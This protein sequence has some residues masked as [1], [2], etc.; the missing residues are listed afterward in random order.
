MLFNFLNSLGI[1]MVVTLLGMNYNLKREV[2]GFH[3]RITGYDPV[4]SFFPDVVKQITVLEMWFH[5]LPPLCYYLRCEILPRSHRKRSKWT[6][7]T[8]KVFLS[9][10]PCHLPPAQDSKV[11]FLG[12]KIHLH[13]LLLW[14]GSALFQ[15]WILQVPAGQSVF[16]SGQSCY[17]QLISQIAM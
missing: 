1:M 12:F 4:K 15:G 11:P 8:V 17:C 14:S 2:S 3:C 7:E 13:H 6:Y 10:C 5:L 16:T 9:A